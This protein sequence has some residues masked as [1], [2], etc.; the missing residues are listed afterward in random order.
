MQEI[1][2]RY[3]KGEP[4]KYLS[5]LDLMRAWQRACRRARLPLAFTQGAPPRPKI[6][7]GPALAVGTAS[8]AEHLVLELQEPLDPSVV[9]E[10]LN[11]SLPAGIQVLQCWSTPAHRRRFALGDLDTSD[12][13]VTIV[14][15]VAPDA[16]CEKVAQFT[17]SS[18]VIYH[19]RRGERGRDLDLRPF[20]EILS[21]EN[22]EPGKAGLHL[23][24][25][26]SGAGCASPHEVIAA[27][28]YASPSFAVGVHRVSLYASGT[29]GKAARRRTAPLLP[30]RR[31][32]K[33]S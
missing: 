20:V 2:C 5:H 13:R 1:V 25:K 16:I 28:G 4:V 19:R 23:R 32:S 3:A 26:A 22:A 31:R 14:G 11:T 27:L 21:V 10:A 8:E 9:Q 6:A 17:Q 12:Y 15:D 7:F 24:L 33:R 18:A 30:R 29:T